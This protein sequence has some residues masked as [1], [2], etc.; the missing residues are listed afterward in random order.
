[1]DR[2]GRGVGDDR[3]RHRVE[4]Q[5]QRRRQRGRPYHAWIRTDAGEASTSIVVIGR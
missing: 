4:S 5:H 3:A 2:A 1:M